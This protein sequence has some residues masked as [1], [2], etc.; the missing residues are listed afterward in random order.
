MCT[1]YVEQIHPLYFV[2]L[3]HLLPHLFQTVFGEFHYAIFISPSYWS[4][5]RQFPVYIQVP[6]YYWHSHYRS[7]FWIR[8]KNTVFGIFELALSRS[9]WWSPVPPIF[10]HMTH[11]RKII[12]FLSIF[13]KEC[14]STYKIPEHLFLQQQI[15]QEP[16]L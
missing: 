5:P 12:P 8:V 6:Y 4:P 2:P 7:R 3:T 9:K 1:V 15:S 11:I 16:R 14:K 10:L 13:P